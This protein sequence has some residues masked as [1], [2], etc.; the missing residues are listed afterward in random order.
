MAPSLVCLPDS[1]HKTAVAPVFWG[2]T[3]PLRAHMTDELLGCAFPPL[4][5]ERLLDRQ[6]VRAAPCVQAV[7]VRPA[8]VHPAPR[9]APV[10]VNLAPQEMPSD[11]PHVLVLAEPRQVLVVHEHR[12][13][14]R[15]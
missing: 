3:G 14:V 4:A 5:D 7:G 2:G 8:L 12:V 10:V 13:D 9:I 11:T 6:Q 15:H 1:Y